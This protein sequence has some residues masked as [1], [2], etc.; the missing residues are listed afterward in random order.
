M[1][2]KIYDIDFVKTE[3]HGMLQYL[4]ENE[5]VYL[6]NQL[7]SNKSY[8]RSRFHEWRKEFSYDDEIRT[9]F[10]KIE[11]ILEGRI[12][13]GA[14]I[15]RLNSSMSMF[16]L[17]NKYGWISNPDNKSQETVPLVIQIRGYKEKEDDIK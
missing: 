4:E 5:Q 14:L 1:P 2:A 6:M 9:L 10:E 3:L 12:A 17:K 15:G 16:V 11:V 13:H 7:F 8:S